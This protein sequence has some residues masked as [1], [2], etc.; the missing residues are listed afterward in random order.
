MKVISII[1]GCVLF[2]GLISVA[3]IWA[4]S[5]SND[6][7]SKLEAGINTTVPT[8][9]DENQSTEQ[10]NS[11]AGNTPN[12]D[13]SDVLDEPQEEV[14][15]PDQETSNNPSDV[16]TTENEQPVTPPSTDSKPSTKPD[17]NN[18]PDDSITEQPSNPGTIGPVGPVTPEGSDPNDTEQNTNEATPAGTAPNLVG[19][20]LEEAEKQVLAAG[21][22]YTFVKE[23]A[24][25]H[26]AG[27]VF[28]QEPAAGTE[29]KKGGRI[30]FYIA[31]GTN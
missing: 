20:S 16:G 18:K 5:L 19:L 8:G 26:E 9:E 14:N 28:K 6:R 11:D 4:N 21:L 13:V 25:G 29:V 12:A 15:N 31:R 30:T 17:T 2:F 23:N 22:K 24:E 1:A 10:P 3:V 27:K 7:N